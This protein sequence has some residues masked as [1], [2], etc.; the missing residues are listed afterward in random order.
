MFGL[1]GEVLAQG[2]ATLLLAIV[3]LMILTGRLVPKRTVDDM[4]ADK[5]LRIDALAIERDTWKAAHTISE[6]ARR[7]ALEQTTQMLELSRTAESVLRALPR[8]GREVNAR[9]LE[10][11]EEG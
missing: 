2:G 1:T 3:V 5:Q 10:A 8:P 9:A 4:R 11:S 6:E 7:A